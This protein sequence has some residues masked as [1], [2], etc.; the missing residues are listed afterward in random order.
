M[1]T[2]SSVFDLKNLRIFILTFL[3]EVSVTASIAFTAK[4]SAGCYSAAYL[5]PPQRGLLV[6]LKYLKTEN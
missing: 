2:N 5:N 1:E 3:R 6:F 4:H